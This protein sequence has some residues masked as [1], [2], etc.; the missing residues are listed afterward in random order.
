M[1]CNL[2]LL[3]LKSELV[4]FSGT[5]FWSLH[6]F[7]CSYPLIILFCLFARRQV[8]TPTL[9]NLHLRGIIRR[10]WTSEMEHFFDILTHWID[11]LWLKLHFIR[12]HQIYGLFIYYPTHPIGY[13]SE[14]PLK[15]FVG[16]IG[17]DRNV[18]CR[19]L[20]R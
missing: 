8:C 16:L 10:L 12:F 20:S 4:T 3:W 5:E 6:I 9:N 18:P 19:S 17:K 1:I 7:C 11:G 14:G 15:W 2:L 13:F